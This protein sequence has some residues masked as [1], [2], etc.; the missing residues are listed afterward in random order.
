MFIWQLFTKPHPSRIVHKSSTTK[1]MTGTN[2]ITPFFFKL[3]KLKPSVQP[4]KGTEMLSHILRLCQKN[5]QH[6]VSEIPSFNHS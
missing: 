1:E 5:M 4:L 6:C 3:D 2:H